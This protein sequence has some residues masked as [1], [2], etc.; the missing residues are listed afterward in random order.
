MPLTTCVPMKTHVGPLGQR[1]ARR[2]RTPGSFSTGNVSPVSVASSTK[3]SLDSSSRQS[4]GMM[5]PAASTTTSP[6]TTSSTGTSAGLPSR[7]HRW[8]HLHDGEELGHGVVRAPLLP[9][10]QQAADR[11][12]A[13]DDDRVRTVAQE[14]TE[15]RGDDQNEDYRALELRQQQAESGGLALGRQGV[16]TIC[17]KAL[18]GLLGRQPLG[19]APNAF[20]TSELGRLQKASSPVSRGPDGGFRLTIL[21]A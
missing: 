17:F 18:R 2:A 6:G 14:D 13:H 3:R 15:D 4:P 12:D 21:V 19:T 8:L 16:G 20:K 5:S 7:M 1:R 9:E 10:S 11:D